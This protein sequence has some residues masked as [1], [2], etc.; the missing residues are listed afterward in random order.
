MA[1]ANELEVIL[2]R[3]FKSDSNA[4]QIL[5]R[6]K[7]Q[8]QGERTL[9]NGIFLNTCAYGIILTLCNGAI[10]ERQKMAFRKQYVPTWY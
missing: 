5:E 9:R 4:M 2:Q 8:I 1:N 7:I 10:L 6:K 3:N